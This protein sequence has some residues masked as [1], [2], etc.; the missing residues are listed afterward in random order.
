MDLDGSGKSDMGQ[1]L[2]HGMR[3]LVAVNSLGLGLS[4]KSKKGHFTTKHNAT[5][6]NLTF[7]RQL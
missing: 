5:L 1:R 2:L 7:S 6:S 3:H 4:Q